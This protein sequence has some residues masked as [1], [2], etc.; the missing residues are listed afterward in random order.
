MAVDEAALTCRRGP[1]GKRVRGE[2]NRA[3]AV[4]NA[5]RASGLVPDGYGRWAVE[6]ILD[7][8][9]PGVRPAQ[10]LVRWRG[11]NPTTGRAWEDSWVLKK[12]LTAD[13]RG[14]DPGY[15]PRGA[16]IQPASR[17]PGSRKTRRL[18]GEEEFCELDERGKERRVEEAPGGG[19]EGGMRTY[20]EER[21]E[22][23]EGDGGRRDGMDCMH[24]AM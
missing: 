16:R 7:K 4:E 20:S 24:V 15:R 6:R 8:T 17:V 2:L 14:T 18:A 3:R 23:K 5:R 13:L 12:Y 9:A 10:A 22:G 11:I 21:R 1:S 19:E